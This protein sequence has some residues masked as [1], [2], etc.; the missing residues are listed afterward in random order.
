MPPSTFGRGAVNPRA[1]PVVHPFEM[2]PTT[3]LYRPLGPAERAL[4]DAFN[5]RI[6]GLIEV[7]ARFPP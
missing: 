7:I 1:A 6:V 5:A 3:T 4:I 2:T